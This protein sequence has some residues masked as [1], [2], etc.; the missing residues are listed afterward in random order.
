MWRT[1]FN[2]ANKKVSWSEE[3]VEK[4]K[5][6]YRSGGITACVKGMS[7][8]RYNQVQSKVYDLIATGELS[9]N[10]DVRKGRPPTKQYKLLTDLLPDGP[11]R[12]HRKAADVKIPKIGVNSVFNMG[13]DPVVIEI[14]PLDERPQPRHRPRRINE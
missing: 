7:H 13:D 3:E 14:K 1:N 5:Q 4:V 9:R 8:R 2:M 10:P 6:L 12:I 11:I